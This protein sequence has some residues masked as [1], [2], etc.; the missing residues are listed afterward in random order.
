MT[1][2]IKQHDKLQYFE[3]V[4]SKFIAW[5]KGDNNTSN[6]SSFTR[7]KLQKLLFLTAAV[8]ATPESKDL[9]VVFN[10]FHA[11]PYGPVESDIYN[12]MTENRFTNISFQERHMVIH[13][14]NQNQ[15]G[16]LDSSILGM[17][18]KATS[19]LRIKNEQLINF[20]ASQLVNITHKWKSWQNAMDIA[21]ILGSGSAKMSIEDICRD[22]KYFA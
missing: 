2:E 18:D 7:L 17:I 21:R 22:F 12:A 9:L 15:F 5:Q 16:H 20:P 14:Q 1:T 10:N 3:Y 13:Q 19:E 6:F 8:N 11:L 4:V